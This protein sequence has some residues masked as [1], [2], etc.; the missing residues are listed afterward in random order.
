MKGK[1]I[2]LVLA[3]L[4]VGL[5]IGSGGCYLAVNAG[6]IRTGDTST[7]NSESVADTSKAG[8]KEQSKIKQ[9]AETL[10]TESGEEASVDGTYPAPAQES[11]ENESPASNSP[12]RNLEWPADQ[13]AGMLPQP[14]TELSPS[15]V[16]T[17]DLTIG[18]T[19]E[20]IPVEEVMAYVD[21]VKNAGY[22]FRASES[23]SGNSYGYDASNNEDTTHAAHISLQY[24]QVNNNPSTFQINWVRPF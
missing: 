24:R 17:S 5:V 9:T 11:P 22:V 21:T 8:D 7:E 1:G 10:T 16:A 2:L 13:L 6:L 14:E 20:N 12:L 23:Q 18:V 19:Y 15:S 4:L 3:G